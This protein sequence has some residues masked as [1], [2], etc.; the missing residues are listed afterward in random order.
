MKSFKWLLIVIGSMG[1]ISLGAC[2]NGQQ[3]DNSGN[4]PTVSSS[5]TT[6]GSQVIEP[7][8]QT[9]EAHMILNTEATPLKTGKSTLMLNVTDAKSGKPLAVKNVAVEMVMSE[10]E[11][12]AMGMEGVGTAKTQIKPT[13]SPGMF[14]IQSSLPYGGNWQLKVNL[15]DIQPTASAVF[16]VA[17]K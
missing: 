7:A 17:V 16:N 2:S 12:K 6:T 14:E 3:V 13:S 11:M 4:N 8:T 9:G 10:Q 5:K 15:K 1:V